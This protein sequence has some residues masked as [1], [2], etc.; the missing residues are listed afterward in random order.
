MA[1]WVTVVT[2]E[3]IMYMYIHVKFITMVLVVAWAGQ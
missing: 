3:S 1:N 2:M